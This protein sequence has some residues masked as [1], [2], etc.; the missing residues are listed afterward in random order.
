MT[1]DNIGS[2]PLRI[3]EALC[4]GHGRCYMLAPGL[5]YADDMGRGQLRT[6]IDPSRILDDL[7]AIVDACPEGAIEKL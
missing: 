7:D 2:A 5:F 6:D 1:D 4:A 3:D